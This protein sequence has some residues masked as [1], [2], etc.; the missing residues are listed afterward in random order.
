MKSEQKHIPALKYNWFQK[1]SAYILLLSFLTIIG[2]C[3]AYGQS[4][5][6]YLILAAERNPA[7]KAKFNEYQASLEKVSQVGALPDPQL[8]FGFFIQPMERYVGNQVAEISLMQM[9]PWFGTLGAA[10]NEATLMAKAKYEAFNEAKTM[11]FYEVKAT[12][13]A[14]Y[15]LEKEIAITEENIQILKTLEEIAINRFKSGGT[16]GGKKSP[17]SGGMQQDKP[18][19]TSGTSGNM[20]GMGMQG[21]TTSGKT[22]GAGNMENM[23]EMS[24]GGSLVDVLRVQMEIN[25]PKNKLALFRDSRQPLVAQFNKL[26]NRLSGEVV[27]LPDRITT[28]MLPVPVA[29]I[30]DSIRQNNPMLK[31]LKMEEEAFLAQE[32]MNRKMGFPM[33]GIGL[34]Y[35]IFQPRPGNESMMN[36]QNMLM[37]MA[38]VSIPL[39]RKKY[40]ASVKEAGFRRE[41]V[42]EQRQDAGN[43][44]LVSYEE[45]LKDYKDATRR[46]ELYQQ[47]TVLAQQAL[48]ILTVQY[49]TA[50]SDFE[51]VLRMQQQLLDYRL[52]G[53]DAI[54][55]QNIAIAM[56]ER[57]MGR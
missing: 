28:A 46:V 14:L 49:T 21:Q 20:S 1:R 29:Q 25:E 54:V 35:G 19:R 18:T 15:L 11:L 26:L 31:M 55:D 39:W 32:K 4:L 53:L 5:N 2:V 56:L 8:S 36:G 41:A 50:G 24:S 3:P 38:T 44:L 12:W 33:I 48:N 34:Q 13:Y 6:D 23:G 42:M 17:G 9:F 27:I 57:L 10:K 52:R 7:L 45:A 51:E 16:S 22:A 47:Q 37:P 30:P 43:Q 40:N